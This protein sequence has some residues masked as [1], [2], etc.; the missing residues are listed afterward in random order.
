MRFRF[1][2]AVVKDKWCVSNVAS[3]WH[4][5]PMDKVYSV[6]VKETL[7]VALGKSAPFIAQ[8]LCPNFPI[9]L[10]QE[11]FDGFFLTVWT[12]YVVDV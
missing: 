8:A 3:I 2:R 12:V 6:S 4:F 9:T 7:I 10:F 1:E 5:A 11:S